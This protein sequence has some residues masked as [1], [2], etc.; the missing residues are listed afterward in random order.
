M[1]MGKRK[2]NR[3]PQKPKEKYGPKNSKRLKE[4]SHYPVNEMTMGRFKYG[5]KDGGY[6][7][8]IP[9]KDQNDPIDKSQLLNKSSGKALLPKQGQKKTENRYS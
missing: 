5:D 4:H 9:I 1:T 2:K 3:R 7:N 6:D 8:W